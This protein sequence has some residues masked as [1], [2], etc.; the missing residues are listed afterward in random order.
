MFRVCEVPCACMQHVEVLTATQNRRL[1]ATPHGHQHHLIHRLKQL[2]GILTPL[3]QL[4][5]SLPPVAGCYRQLLLLTQ[6]PRKAAAEEAGCRVLT[7]VAGAQHGNQQ[8]HAHVCAAFCHDGS[9]V[10][11]RGL[12]AKSGTGSGGLD[13]R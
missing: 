10:G 11:K 6:S 7:K 2:T 9:T 5:Q 1:T 12:R 13:R 8:H 3:L 4:E